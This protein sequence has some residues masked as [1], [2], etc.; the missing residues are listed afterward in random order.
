[1]MEEMQQVKSLLIQKL[2]QMVEKLIPNYF[3][4]V[5]GSHATGLCL[6]WSDIDL[7]VGSVS[8]RDQA[9]SLK[10][11][12]LRIRDSLKKISDG[13]KSE[14]A[15]GWVIL[16][17]Y[18]DMAS[19]PVIKVKCSL[20]ELMLQAG[21]QFPKNPK[22]AAIYQQNFSIDITHMTE[23]HNGVK[24]V[25]LVKDY[26]LECWFIEPI[27]L[28]LKQMLKV[29]GMNDPYKG[30]LSSYGLLL[31]IVAFIQFRQLNNHKFPQKINLGNI[32]LDFLHYYGEVLQF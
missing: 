32:L 4:E 18:I 24:C 16:V 25:N 11:Q 31:M 23:F 28:V 13:L 10:M 15:S 8:E 1:M 5:Y 29:N 7:V 3:V 27:I 2:T 9:Q 26:L 30:G 17:N 12:E 21:M 19:V 14:I 20:K 6:H 22:Y